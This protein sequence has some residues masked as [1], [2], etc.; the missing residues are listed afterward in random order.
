MPF[1]NHRRVIAM[2]FELL[3]QREAIL[4]DQRRL[5]PKQNTPSELR[6]PRVATREQGVAC[7]RANGCRTVRIGELHALRGEGIEMRR[8]HLRLRIE[9]RHIAITEIVREDEDDIGQGGCG[10]SRIFFG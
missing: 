8:L 1:A 6:A 9:A 3:R 2:T 4:R 5:E 10:F 7:G